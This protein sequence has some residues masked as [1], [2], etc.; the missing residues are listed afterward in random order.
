MIKF[1]EFLGR[2]VV[3]GYARA[4][5]V[6]RK[7]ARVEAKAAEKLAA[8]SQAAQLASQDASWEAKRLEEKTKQ[9]KA[10]FS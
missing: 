8:Q 3:R 2:L 6:E 5:S 1:I 4:A 9:L 7:V 10:F